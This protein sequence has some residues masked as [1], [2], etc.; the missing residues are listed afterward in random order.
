MAPLHV[1]VKFTDDQGVTH[2]LEATSGAG[3]ARDLH[4]RRL[5]PITDKAV[6]NGVFLTPLTREQ[7][8]AVIATVLVED[9]I[10]RKRYHDAMAVANIILKH[11]PNFAYLMV[12]KGTAAYYLLQAEFRDKYADA[13]DIPQDQRAYFQYLQRVN[14][15]SFAQ[16]DA[17]GWKPMQQ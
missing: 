9:L 4:Y 16:A 3:R 13:N 15:S 8:V 17:L 5:M 11:Y 12:K 10:D 7:T 14:Q 1:F 2:N 6:A